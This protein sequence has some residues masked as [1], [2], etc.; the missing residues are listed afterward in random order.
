MFR[1]TVRIPESL[2]QKVKLR[3]V[4]E[5]RAIQAL[6]KDALEQYLRKP[7]EEER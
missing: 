7:Q 5:K 6:L 2:A 1:M 3:A 4:R